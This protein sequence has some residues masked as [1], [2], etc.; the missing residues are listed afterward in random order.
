M[1]HR[2]GMQ[3]VGGATSITEADWQLSLCLIT[4]MCIQ[5]I[6]R[7]VVSCNSAI[8]ALEKGRLW[9]WV[10]RWTGERSALE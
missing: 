6:P 8:S 1:V 2:V 3:C 4:E 10:A 9:R 5:K 7:D